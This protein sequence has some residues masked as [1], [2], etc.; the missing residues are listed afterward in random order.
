MIGI[1]GIRN[2]INGK[3][4]IGQAKD[5]EKRN[6]NEKRNIKKGY[7][8]PNTSANMHFNRAIAKYGAGAFSFHI[9]E[10]CEEEMLN[11]REIFYIKQYNSL[12]PNGYN[13]TQGGTSGTKGYKFTDSQ[14]KRMSDVQKQMII[15]GRNKNA[16]RKG[17]ENPMFGKPSPNRGKSV[18]KEIVE[19]AMKNRRSFIG[20]GNPNYG[21]HASD[22]TKEIWHEQRKGRKLSQEWKEKISLNSK[23]AK[24]VRC[25]ETGEIFSSCVLA[26]K[27]H[28]IKTPRNIGDVANGKLKTCGGFTWEWETE[29]KLN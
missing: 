22:K 21:K 12:S 7:I 16:F 14:K 20:K 5:I 8:H 26:A 29:V 28:G 11:E 23:S 25:I 4:Y 18:P 15:D 9:I 1:Y 27:A 10:L 24:K 13:L 17:K 19:K 2:D 3:W 6:K